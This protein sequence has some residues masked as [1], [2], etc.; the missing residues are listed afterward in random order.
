MLASHCQQSGLVHQVF[1]VCTGE[2]G[3]TLCNGLEVNIVRQRLTACMDLE[4][5]LPAL[6]IGHADIDLTVKTTRAQ[7]R[8]IENIRAVCCRHDYDA[9]VIAETVHL[10]KQLV[11][12]LLALIVSAAE[13]GAALAADG[14][15]LVDEYDS[16]S[17]LL[18][19]VEQVAH[20]RCA[21][22]DIKLNK[23][24][25][26]NGQKLHA[27][28]ACNR[29]CEQGLTCSRGAYKQNALGYSCAHLGKRFRILEE[30]D[31][32]LKLCL[33]LIGACNVVK[34]L[35]VFLFAAE[36]R[37]G[38]AEFHCAACASAALCSLHHDDPEHHEADE[39][40][41]RDK[42]QPPRRLNGLDLIILDYALV[43]LLV[44]K[45]A[46]LFIEQREA[47]HLIVYGLI[48]VLC[49]RVLDLHL[50]KILRAVI[51]EFLN[52]FILEKIL[53]LSIAELI[54]RFLVEQSEQ[55]ACKQHQYQNIKAYISRSVAL[56][57]QL[58]TSF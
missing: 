3:S 19:L 32:L 39:Q 12:C 55:S 57:F 11:E 53:D 31:K 27:R 28:F 51:S 16:R 18:C 6:Y 5:G 2:A 13:A 8:V 23:V 35:S 49:A 44:D 30:F 43:V 34:R 38:L 41:I 14:V 47:V 45:V 1:K 15:D 4:Y 33:F 52:L 17:D 25:T 21:D 22:A 36:S 37:P 58:I 46:E 10:N 7:Q 50:K 42:L 40:D 26:G 20:T 56:R 24:G 9:L 29:F 48:A 54:L